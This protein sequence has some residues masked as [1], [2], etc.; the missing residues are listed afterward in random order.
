[1]NTVMWENGVV[2]DK[3][4]YLRSKGYFFVGPVRGHLACGDEGLGHIAPIEQITSE[5][6]KIIKK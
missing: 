4:N 1:M 2:Q 6:E 5:T 3:V